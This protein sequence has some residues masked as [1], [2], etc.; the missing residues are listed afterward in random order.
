MKMK[1]N[2]CSIPARSSSVVGVNQFQAEYKRQ[3]NK[4]QRLRV[5]LRTL[6]SMGYLSGMAEEP[7]VKEFIE[8]YQD[9]C[10]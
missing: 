10:E 2:V 6:S 5:A 3:K 9:E 4:G 8:D 1:A 7:S